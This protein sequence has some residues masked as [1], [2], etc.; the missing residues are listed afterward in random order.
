MS[1][2]LNCVKWTKLLPSQEENMVA[3]NSKGFFHKIRQIKHRCLHLIFLSLYERTEE[4]GTHLGTCPGDRGRQ[5]E[6]EGHFSIS[7]P[8]L[9][10]TRGVEDSHWQNRQ[11]AL[12]SWNFTFTL[13][14]TGKWSQSFLL[15]GNQWQCPA[16]VISGAY[17]GLGA[18]L[19]QP[20]RHSPL[21]SGKWDT[22]YLNIYFWCKKFGI[23][24]IN[25][26]QK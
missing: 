18:D 23:G 9:E 26:I 14:M 11:L 3:R 24:Q 1:C 16:R 10:S 7:S 13:C 2:A 8:L 15:L 4:A 6:T 21:H 17:P 5:R 20:H 22:K 25:T 12:Q 19:G